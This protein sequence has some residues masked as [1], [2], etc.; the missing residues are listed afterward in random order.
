MKKKKSVVIV[1]IL[2]ITLL[3]FA[4]TVKTFQNDTFYTIKIGESILEHGIDMK[5][6][7]SW[8]NLDYTYPHWLYDI[9]VYKI[10]D[11]GGFDGIYISNILIFI[12]SIGKIICNFAFANKINLII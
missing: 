4:F 8:H 5:D 10:Y 1:G 2:I 7:F 3:C 9:L 12:V 6:H 11:I